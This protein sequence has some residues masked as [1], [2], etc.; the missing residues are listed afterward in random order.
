MKSRG[1]FWTGTPNV[2]VTGPWRV[3]KAVGM[4][5]VI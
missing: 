3:L 2:A 1:E 4:G 5:E